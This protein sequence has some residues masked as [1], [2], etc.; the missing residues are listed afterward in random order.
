MFT[1]ASSYSNG[2]MLKSSNC[3][4][5][6]PVYLWLCKAGKGHVTLTAI[7][8][9]DRCFWSQGCESSLLYWFSSMRTIV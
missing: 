5:F 2:D 7:N 6:A 9:P 3:S 4:W 8:P 1:Q